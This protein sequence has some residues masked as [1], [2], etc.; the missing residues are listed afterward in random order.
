V[1]D[2]Q[3]FALTSGPLLSVQAESWQVL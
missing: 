1:P 2:R 3:P